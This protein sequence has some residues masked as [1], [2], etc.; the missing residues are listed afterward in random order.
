MSKPI[1]SVARRAQKMP[2]IKS[3]YDLREELSTQHIVNI[4]DKLN[5]EDGFESRENAL[6]A[7]SDI[8]TAVHNGYHS[9]DNIQVVLEVVIQTLR[10]RPVSYY[11]MKISKSALAKKPLIMQ[12]LILMQDIVVKH[13][14]QCLQQKLL[15]LAISMH[16]AVMLI[17]H[18]KK[19][20]TNN[21]L[22]QFKLAQFSESPKR[23][24][25]WNELADNPEMNIAHI[26]SS[27]KGILEPLERELESNIKKEA[28]IT[29]LISQI[30][31]IIAAYQ[32]A[33]YFK[34]FIKIKPVKH[35]KP[36]NL[37][38]KYFWQQ[39]NDESSYWEENDYGL[40]NKEPPI[41][42]RFYTPLTE[43][44]EGLT[45]SFEESIDHYEAPFFS[46]ENLTEPSIKP[47]TSV[48]LQHIDLSLQQNHISQRDLAL[49]SNIRVLP[50]SS[51]QA[52]F[53]A[54]AEDTQ[55]SS[56][57]LHRTCANVLL[58]SMIT[59]LP[60]NSLL[61]SGYIGHPRIFI[62]GVN[63][64][65]IEHSLGI[66]KRVAAF[67]DSKHENQ[68]DMI[69][70]PVPQGLI[71]TI[72]EYDLPFN[73]DIQDYLTHL[74]ATIGL[75]YLS[76]KRIE[77]ALHVILSRYT[78]GSHSHIADIICRTPAPHAPA[79]YY[80]SHRSE[81]I[82]AHY[83]SALSV[84]NI[85]DNFDVSYITAWHKYSVGSGSALT[86]DYVREIVTNLEAWANESVDAN[87]RFNRTSIFVWF[88]FCLLTGV[89][90]NNGIGNMS[91][92]DLEM[93]WLVINDKP[94]KQVQNHRLIPL[95]PTLLNCL[96]AYRNYLVDY[97][98]NN[99]LKHEISAT[100]DE[101]GLGNDVAL[102]RLLSENFDA[103]TIIK[104]GDAYQ[105]TKQIIDAN[106]YWTRH[107]V[108]TQL[109]K[110]EVDMVLINAVIGHEKARQEG[111]GRFSSLSKSQIKSVSRAFEQISVR[112][113]LDKITINR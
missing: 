8:V 1:I 107:F 81:D 2:N 65:Y 20:H 31:K 30:S 77:T 87:T 28:Q 106:P 98:L 108:R 36:I 14:K 74:R 100:I 44:Y 23:T 9:T 91:D 39:K 21:I 3:Q 72:L 104:R 92:I 5:K 16:T 99:L 88:I 62:I 75:P 68:F 101:I 46:Y 70:I 11:D 95:C 112:L 38:E 78:S 50:K 73:E 111:L 6:K 27:L 7:I 57:T 41:Q 45:T 54:L 4:I 40:Y 84:L 69:K 105:M 22:M 113:G 17:H 109:E 80:S 37:A 85:A 49:N 61:I 48:P 34:K 89:R 82:F 90:P 55:S 19:T 52:V 29:P 83:K 56:N 18:N 103:L 42:H 33:H 12:L 60:V 51:Y 110:M 25:I 15:W 26:L 24:W 94:S 93:G 63:R 64:S 71:E 76:V 67:D 35:I 96:T 66:T 43:S 58:L 59:A 13:Q 102:L 47:F 97:Q 32:Y 86:P 10:T 79:M 53:S